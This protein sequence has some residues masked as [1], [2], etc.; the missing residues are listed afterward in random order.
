[1]L[2]HRLIT[3]HHP[4]HAEVGQ[5]HVPRAVEEDVLGL[6]PAVDDLLV[7]GVPQGMEQLQEDLDRQLWRDRPRQLDDPPQAAAADELGDDVGVVLAGIAVEG[8]GD[9]RV[10]ELTGLLD[11]LVEPLDDLL[12]LRLGEEAEQLTDLFDRHLTVEHDLTREKDGTDPARPD[13]L[14]LLVALVDQVP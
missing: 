3:L 6:D 10:R 4:G 7:V 1:M 12:A 14:D 11:L 5:S 8:H 2:D 13:G 9:V